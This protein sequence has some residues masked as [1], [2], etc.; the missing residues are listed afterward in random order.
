MISKLEQDS[1]KKMLMRRRE[2]R[3]DGGHVDDCEICG[4]RMVDL[5]G[6]HIV[7]R[8]HE[9][10]ADHDFGEIPGVPISINE[11]ENGLL[12][13]SICHIE[14]D[15]TASKIKERSIQITEDATIQILG[16]KMSVFNN[17]GLEGKKVPW[18]KLIGVKDYPSK[19]LLKYAYGLK[20]RPLTRK[21]VHKISDVDNVVNKV[22]S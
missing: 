15:K 6:V 12:L 4:K 3:V 13:C 14:F 21:R 9:K 19:E 8:V 10:K 20:I 7:D 18:A 2:A 22:K 17:M 5:E 16:S 11:A 1:F